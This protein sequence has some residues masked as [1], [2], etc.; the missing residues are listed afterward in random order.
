M[1]SQFF[2]LLNTYFTRVH[3]GLILGVVVFFIKYIL[4]SVHF[5][6][7][8]GDVFFYNIK[9]IFDTGTFSVNTWCH[10]F[11]LIHFE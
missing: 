7:R 10:R 8:H 11:F 2:T 6:L 5:Q 4:I 1:V 3:F 9:Y